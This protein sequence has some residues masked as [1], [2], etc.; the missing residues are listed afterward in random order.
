[1][2]SSHLFVFLIALSL[3]L[4]IASWIAAAFGYPVVSLLSEESFRWWTQNGLHS[5]FSPWGQKAIVM[6]L[7]MSSLLDACSKK[8]IEKTALMSTLAVSFVCT[9]IICWLGMSHHS[10]LLNVIG[11]VYPHSPFLDGLPVMISLSVWICALLYAYLSQR[12]TT[13]V[14]AVMF[15]FSGLRNRP[16]WIGII[17]LLSLNVHIIL[18]IL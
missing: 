12:I 13:L 7:A 4:P 17:M 9:S 1:M 2:R 3:I 10:P 5:V 8:S 16:E 11:A 14:E 6:F 15:I 18:Y